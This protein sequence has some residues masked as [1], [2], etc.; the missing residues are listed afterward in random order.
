MSDLAGER[1]NLIHLDEL[2]PGGNKYYKLK[3]NLRAAR[4]SGFSRI[5]SFAGAWSNHILELARAGRE[6]GFE[7][8]GVIRGEQPEQLSATLQDAVALGM[9]LEFV[10]RSIYRNRTEP[11]LLQGLQ[12]Q[13]GEFYHLPEGGTNPLAVQGCT[14][15]VTALEQHLKT[16]D[17]VCLPVGTGG[18]LAGIAAALP[19]DKQVLGF[20]VVK[21][22]LYLDDVVRDL[23]REE[24]DGSARD[25]WSINHDYHC[26]GYARCPAY[27][28]EFILDFERQHPI[29]LEPVYSGK[30]MY[31][32]AELLRRQQIDSSMSIAAIH[33]GGLQGRRGFDF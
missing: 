31:G 9:R 24:S 23:I 17:L 10:S 18:T 25:N 28:Q 19:V 33:T 3:Y 5:L 22:A 30:L 12:Q 13:F 14:E 16:Y 4:K 32:L 6:Q 15:I 21:G 1:L 26:G 27:L 7:T 20:A 8:I 11:E 29:R 2:H